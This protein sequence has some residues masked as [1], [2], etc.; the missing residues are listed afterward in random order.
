MRSSESTRGAERY[1]SDAPAQVTTAFVEEEW[2]AALVPE[3][4]AGITGQRGD[5]WHAF[6][7]ERSDPEVLVDGDH[8]LYRGWA[9]R[10]GAD[11]DEQAIAP[12]AGG[13]LAAPMP[14]TVLRVLVAPGDH[15][16]AGQTLVLLEAMKMELAVAAPGDGVVSAVH[17]EA[18]ELVQGGAALAEIE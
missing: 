2:S 10:L 17:V 7:S 16:A 3:L 9:Y 18:G 1:Q 11:D 6:G 14:G 12:L 4:P 15:V 5:V 13:S 8:A